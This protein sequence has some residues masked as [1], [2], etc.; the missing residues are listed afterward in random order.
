MKCQE[1]EIDGYKHLSHILQYH[2]TDLEH[3][4][5][6]SKVAHQIIKGF[7]SPTHLSTDGAPAQEHPLGLQAPSELP[8]GSQAINPRTRL[9]EIIKSLARLSV[10][11]PNEV[12]L[13]QHVV[14]A[15]EEE[16]NNHKPMC[17]FT[18]PDDKVLWTHIEG[19]V[20]NFKS[21]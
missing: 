4:K 20:K 7:Y 8:S 2:I 10:Q 15:A 21:F 9:S 19:H 3:L 17:D 1:V 6:V 13:A 5:A 11:C 16:L 12:C 14:C 18:S